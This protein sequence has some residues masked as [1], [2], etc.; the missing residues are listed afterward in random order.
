[1]ATDLDA[2]D[3]LSRTPE[4]VAAFVAGICEEEL[5][6]RPAKDVFSLRENVLHLRDI[7]IE[8]YEKRIAR[9]LTEERPFLRDVNGAALARERDY[10]AQ[11]I[12][13]ALEAFRTSRSVSIARLRQISEWDL[14]RVA[15]LEGVGEVTLRQ[16]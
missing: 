3:R 13:P 5:S 8:G 12:G 1:M 9:M 6:R 14:D 11:P 16:L 7:D 15:Q 2:I 10:N 4:M